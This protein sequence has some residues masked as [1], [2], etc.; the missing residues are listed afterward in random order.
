MDENTGTENVEAAEAKPAE[1]PALLKGNWRVQR[2]APGGGAMVELY[3]GPDFNEACDVWDAEMAKS[4][5]IGDLKMLAPGK[6]PHAMHSRVYHRETHTD[7]KGNQTVRARHVES[8]P[9]PPAAK[10]AENVADVAPAPAEEKESDLLD[11]VLQVWRTVRMELAGYR[12]TIRRAKRNR[13]RFLLL[14]PT[15]LVMNRKLG[16]LGAVK[17]AASIARMT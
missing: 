17:R 14:V 3:K 1:I 16:V 13:R 5:W 10:S 8:I 6:K 2:T 7:D 11:E 9:E 12:E 15:S 4:G